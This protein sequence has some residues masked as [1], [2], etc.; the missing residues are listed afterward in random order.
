MAQTLAGQGQGAVVNPERAV[1]ARMGASVFLVLDCGKT[2]IEH[3]TEHKLGRCQS[4]EQ[5]CGLWGHQKRLPIIPTG[6]LAS[7]GHSSKECFPRGPKPGVYGDPLHLTPT[8]QG[9]MHSKQSQKVKSNG[10]TCV[11]EMGLVH[12]RATEAAAHGT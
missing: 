11:Q 4:T 12:P 7:S 8:R 6:S 1:S 10:P 5:L 9:S 3:K 2:C